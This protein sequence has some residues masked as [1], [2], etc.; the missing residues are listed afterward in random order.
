M[1]Q[2]LSNSGICT[3]HSQTQNPRSCTCTS[4]DVRCYSRHA[5]GL[6][7]IQRSRTVLRLACV[8]GK[9]SYH[10]RVGQR[11]K[12]GRLRAWRSWYGIGPSRSAR[13]RLRCR[14]R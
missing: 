4:A 11:L 8:G 3:T 1:Q 14:L 7:V 9:R 13:S 12:W 10:L 2:W 6:T 5:R